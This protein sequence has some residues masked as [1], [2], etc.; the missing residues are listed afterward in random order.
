MAIYR[1]RN[2]EQFT[3]IS[4]TTIRDMRLSNRDLGALVRLLSLADNWRFS[5][6]GLMAGHVM[7]DGREAISNA[8]HSLERS[9]YLTRQ[10]L[11]GEKGVFGGCEWE[12]FE[13]PTIADSPSTGKPESRHPE[14]GSPQQ[15]NTTI[16]I[17]D[18]STKECVGTLSRKDYEEL[19]EQYGKSLVEE[20]IMRI[21][22]R[23]YSG[24]MTRETIAQWCEERRQ[25]KHTKR[26][27]SFN[28]YPQRDY[29]FDEF[30]REIL[31]E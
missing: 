13:S 5:V 9:G 3:V 4:N 15:S 12:V 6:K 17:N 31:G 10:L 23:H 7:P 25:R 1:E 21:K 2:R 16:S 27:N 11:K 28:E 30:E 26:A 14:T 29:D 19:V 18:T 8:L 24:C 22:E 20:I